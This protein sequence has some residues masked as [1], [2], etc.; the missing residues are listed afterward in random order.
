MLCIRG[1]LAARKHADRLLLLVEMM[2]GSAFPCFKAGSRTLPAL[3]RRFA[4]HLTEPQARLL[5]LWGLLISLL[6]V[7]CTAE[8]GDRQRNHR[9]RR[10]LLWPRS[11]RFF[12]AS[13]IVMNIQPRTHQKHHDHGCRSAFLTMPLKLI[14]GLWSSHFASTI[15]DHRVSSFFCLLCSCSHGKW[16]LPRTGGRPRAGPH[17]RKLG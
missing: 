10:H 4:Q 15:S 12:I 13:P 17:W 2:E 9:Q 8:G 7:K 11:L 5:N 14:P 16:W 1:F 3:R 6:L